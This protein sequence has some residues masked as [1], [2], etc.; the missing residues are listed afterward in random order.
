MTC[1]WL[2]L[3]ARHP[4]EGKAAN[5]LAA[6]VCFATKG[7]QFAKSDGS[8]SHEHVQALY[9]SRS[10]G[11]DF[12]RAIVVGNGA[13]ASAKEAGTQSGSPP[14]G[15]DRAR[16][17][18]RARGPDRARRTDRARRAGNGGHSPSL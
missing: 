13:T 14:S 12:C 6:A 2:L 17:A 15:A 5:S 10:V 16:R 8:F 9:G 18:D 4:T 1:T 3:L 11:V 7:W